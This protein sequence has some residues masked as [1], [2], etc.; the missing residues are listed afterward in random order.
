VARWLG[1]QRRIA[2]DIETGKLTAD[3]ALNPRFRAAMKSHGC[4]P[5]MQTLI[6]V[7]LPV[8]DVLPAELAWP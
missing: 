2:D 8:D 1:V 4:H 7:L 6:H 3:D 5:V